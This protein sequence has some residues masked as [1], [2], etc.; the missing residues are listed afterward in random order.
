MPSPIG[1]RDAVVA[2]LGCGGLGS[3]VATLL[4]R[5]GVGELVLVDFDVVDESNLSRQMFF[6]DQIGMPKPVALAATLQRIDPTVRLTPYVRRMEAHT[7][8]EL[9]AGAHVVVEAV[10]QAETKAMIANTVMEISPD[11]PLVMGSGLAGVSDA[12]EIVTERLSETLWVVGDQTSDIREGL[13]LFS[14][15]VMI[16]AAHQAHAVIRILLGRTESF[17]SS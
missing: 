9:I 12:N 11:T 3:N 8:A 1:L 16:A 4:V 6:R 7:I 17:E 2:V 15:R 5:A 10:D 14:S 13:P